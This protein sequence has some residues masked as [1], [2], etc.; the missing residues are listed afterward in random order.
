[1]LQPRLQLHDT[2]PTHTPKRKV[3]QLVEKMP[4]KSLLIAEIGLPTSTTDSSSSWYFTPI[5]DYFD[6]RDDATSGICFGDLTTDTAR[7][8]VALKPQD[9]PAA[10]L[11]EFYI[12][13]HLNDK[14]AIP[15][16]EPLGFLRDRHSLY[17][18][19]Q[20][21]Q[22]VVSCDAITDHTDNR[23]QLLSVL[24]LGALT[25]SSLHGAGVAH[26]DAQIKNTAFHL[27]TH[28]AWA[29]DLSSSYFNKGHRGILG[30]LISYIDTLPWH[31]H[32]E[33]I[34]SHDVRHYFLDPYLEVLRGSFSA[35]K[36]NEVRSAIQDTLLN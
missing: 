28:S 29:I 25:L 32:G 20:F 7:I 17:T 14:G 2:L 8:P 33:G 31:I 27:D 1:M 4:D 35:K 12:A 9:T 34:S 3:R 26:G 15:T 18:I 11:N 6:G 23:E 21:E 36:H 13:Q 19:T 5:D 10:A 22:S 30:D 16:F 24:G